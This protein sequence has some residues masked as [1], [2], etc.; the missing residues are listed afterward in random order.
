[1]VQSIT[2]RKANVT[3]IWRG[4][5]LL[6][7]NKVTWTKSCVYET[8]L[9]LGTDTRYPAIPGTSAVV[10]DSTQLTK[11]IDYL[12]LW[13]GWLCG[14]CY[15]NVSVQTIQGVPGGK[16]NILEGYSIG[17]SKQKQCT[18]TCV[19]F[20][21]VSEIKLFHYTV[22]KLLITKR[23]YVLFPIPVF[24]VQVTKLVQFFFNFLLLPL[25]STGLISQFLDHS[26]IV[27]VFRRV[28]S[29][30]QGRYLNTG[31]HTHIE[32]PCPEWDSNRR[33]RLPN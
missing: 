32:H 23:Y 9:S 31:Q 22:P 28:I 21:T 17:H 18:C 14:S 24:T 5:K 11:I 20:R 30:S 25:W 4:T 27:G 3:A 13:M 15:D 19:L 12:V 26:Q 8:L 29:S 33:S 16:L 2:A 7:S 10:P 6:L 1:M